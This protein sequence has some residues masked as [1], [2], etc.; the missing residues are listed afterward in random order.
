MT[1]VFAL[2]EK[3]AQG[4]R[5]REVLLLAEAVKGCEQQ[6]DT[7]CDEDSSEQASVAAPAPPELGRRWRTWIRSLLEFRLLHLEQWDVLIPSETPQHRS[8]RH[9]G[10][11][12]RSD[13][14]ARAVRLVG[15]SF[16]LLLIAYAVELQQLSSFVRTPESH[17]AL[18][19]R[20]LVEFV[21]LVVLEK[22]HMDDQ[23]CQDQSVR[24]TDCY[25]VVSMRDF[26]LRDRA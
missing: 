9:L 1:L 21:I 3:M 11:S 19:V 23:G 13:L 7:G 15:S 14:M 25:E 22:E 2:A 4:E 12:S 16:L 6:Q 18:S 10:S 5:G 20:R 24:E 8:E 17:Q 26:A